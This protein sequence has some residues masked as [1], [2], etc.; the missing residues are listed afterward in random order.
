MSPPSQPDDV[1]SAASAAPLISY[2]PGAFAGHLEHLMDD[3]DDCT[4][5]RLLFCGGVRE[6]RQQALATLTRYA[7]GNVHQFQV[8]SL[9]GEYRMQT[10]NNLRKAFDHGSEENALLYFDRAGS[11]FAH[12]HD[13][14]SDDDPQ[15]VPSTLEYFFDR[16]GAYA[17][18]VV[19]GLQGTDHAERTRDKV[20]LVV[21][22][23]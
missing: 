19:L 15:A 22:F 16:V 21:Q 9:L 18:M 7:T 23:E 8:P 20:H 17:G 6:Q 12:T 14:A 2:D 5:T 13:D 3:E 11:L 10:Q 4:G 1:D